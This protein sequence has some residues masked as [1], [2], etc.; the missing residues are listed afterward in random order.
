MQRTL[1]VGFIGG[2]KNSAVGRTHAVASQ[3]DGRWEL[4]AGAFSRHTDVNLRTGS[5][6]GVDADRT[7]ASWT[8]LVES[9]AGRLDAVVVLT[10]TPQH[11]E[12]V[13]AL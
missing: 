9:E 1:K 4:V 5:D 7:Y 10:P 12:Q 6:W 2:G 13:L 8:Q 3:M 11:D